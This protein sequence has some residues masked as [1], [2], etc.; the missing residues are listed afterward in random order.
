MH[1][2]TLVFIS[3][4][5][6]PPYMLTIWSY[7]YTATYQHTSK[8]SN[9]TLKPCCWPFQ[10]VSAST[11]STKINLCVLT[12][13]CIP[14]WHHSVS[15]LDLSL[16]LDLTWSWVWLVLCILTLCHNM[17]WLLDLSGGLDS[18]SLLVLTWLSAST[19][20]LP[21]VLITWLDFDLGSSLWLCMLTWLNLRVLFFLTL[22]ILIN[23]WLVSLNSSLGLHSRLVIDFTLGCNFTSWFSMT[24]ALDFNW[25][26]G[27]DFTIGGHLCCL[28]SASPLNSDFVS[29]IGICVLPELSLRLSVLTP[30]PSCDLF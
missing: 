22:A 3:H 21:L 17:I 12:L 4:I 19:I 11:A 6:S 26:V 8:I 27:V 18:P 1:L 23:T 14:T 28:D 24:S 15:W 10:P 30:F 29:W 20:N 5:Y 7:F 13:P 25:T 9:L 2:H 16:G